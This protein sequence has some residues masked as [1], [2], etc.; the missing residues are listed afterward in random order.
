[1]MDKFKKKFEKKK[2]TNTKTEKMANQINCKKYQHTDFLYTLIHF[3]FLIFQLCILI[4]G[5]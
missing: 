1:M 2:P 5:K 3:K 4:F